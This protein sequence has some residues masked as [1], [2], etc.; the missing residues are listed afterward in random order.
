MLEQ[1]LS[2]KS[3]W[4]VG[5]HYG[6]QGDQYQRFIDEGIWENGYSD[7]HIDQVK[8][9]QAGD[10]I[11]IKSAYTRKKPDGLPFDNNGYSVSVMAI[12]AIGVIT[13][14]YNDGKTVK[15]D[16]QPL[17]KNREW[18]FFTNRSVIWKVT[19]DNWAT[20][21]LINFAFS[22]EEQDL[23][24][25]RNA[26]YWKG[27]FGDEIDLKQFE[28]TKFY[29]EL[30]SKLLSCRADRSP[31]I[32]AI[33]EISLE[34]NVK[35]VLADKY[36]NGSDDLLDDICPFTVFSL[37]NRENMTE[38][39][40]RDIARGLADF[41]GVFQVLPENFNG[42][43]VLA[44]AQS[45]FFGFAKDRG[46][47]DIELL[48]SVFEKAIQFV[49]SDDSD[50]SIKNEFL[51]AYDKVIPVKWLTWNLTTG[52][53]WARPWHFVSLDK[54]SPSFI[55]TELQIPIP[56]IT[57]RY[58]PNADE[59]LSL[60]NDLLRSFEDDSFAVHSFP[61]LSLAACDY[62]APETSK[63]T[64]GKE[65]DD[66]AEEVANEDLVGL[67]KPLYAPYSVESI[68]EDGCFLDS[69][70]IEEILKR[71]TTKKNIIL[72]G[73]PGT[74]KT[75]L[76]KRLAFALLGEKAIKRVKAVQFHP[77][78]SYEDFVRGYRPSEG[79]KLELS[80][81]PFLEMINNALAD[82]DSFHVLVIEEINRGNPA[83]IFGEMLTL[84]EESKRT[85]DEALELCYRKNA[86]ERVYIPDNLFV[87]G[88]MN[89]ADRSLALVDF[90]LRR[91]F[92]FIEL[93]PELGD[94]WKDWV[95]KSRGI[96]SQFLSDIQGRIER[97]NQQIA[98][99]RSLGHQ[100]KIG[101]SYFVPNDTV[102]DEKDWFIQ[103]V[104]T[105]VGPLLEEYW[106]DDLDK[107]S[108]AKNQLKLGL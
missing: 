43:T 51:E 70:K 54:K 10:K 83:Q 36:S 39:E 8:S 27:R 23:N 72:Q 74:G 101:H 38:T 1:D 4:F 56:E 77:N 92:A 100:F 64:S 60:R 45:R 16:W 108:E 5:C 42:V 30:A 107:A 19:P 31:L 90:A 106:F 68:I 103:T 37:F 71:L 46:H 40:R 58:R 35:S 29:E 104:D 3:C 81:G 78:L 49:D 34:N 65:L 32:K 91:R 75:W 52:L 98:D 76:A 50:L 48:W 24:M 41:L 84:L 102:E 66:M 63:K 79:G 99:D 2:Q 22:S 61:E 88:T 59:Y 13:E 80:D 86:N 67:D 69:Q 93:K 94:S 25:F 55:E 62:E 44:N 89:I 82:P 105:E 11:A 95:H 57:S 9:M 87:I 14:N 12:K 97:L 15:V 73:P 21:G 85:P 33:H 28:W 96:S 18:Y 53:Y 6:K 20:D 7:K 17:E 47:D 26:P